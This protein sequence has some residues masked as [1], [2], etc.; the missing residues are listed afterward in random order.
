MNFNQ[1]MFLTTGGLVLFWLAS[2]VFLYFLGVPI[3]IQYCMLVLV[4]A[5]NE[6]THRVILEP[7]KRRIGY[8]EGRV[9]MWDKLD[10]KNTEITLLKEELKQAE[11]KK[12]GRKRK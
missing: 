1:K 7:N 12:N 9:S 5:F 11:Q 3:I 10:R 6:Y 4:W 8:Y 2:G